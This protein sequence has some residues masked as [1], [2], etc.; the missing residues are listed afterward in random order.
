[1]EFIYEFTQTNSFLEIEFPVPKGTTNK[2]ISFEIGEGWIRVG[3][4]GKDPVICGQLVASVIPKESSFSVVD[5]SKVVVKIHKLGEAI[6]PLIIRSDYNG[7]MDANSE[8]MLSMFYEKQ[9]NIPRAYESLQKSVKKKHYAGIMKMAA[10]YTYQSVFPIPVD[11]KKA[12]ELWIES[13]KQ[14]NPDSQYMVG[15]FY[16]FG[17]SCEKNYAKAIEFYQKSHE[18]GN[19][20][21]GINAGALYY[22]GGYGIKKNLPLAIKFWQ[23]SSDR[24]KQP[25]AMKNLSIVYYLGEGIE[26]DIHKAK[27][28]LSQALSIDPNLELSPVLE[29]LKKIKEPEEETEKPKEIQKIQEIKETEKPKEIQEIK[30]IKETQKPKETKETQKS[31]EIKEIKRN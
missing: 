26:K 31:K 17:D 7:E 4:K 27:E 9:G 8:Y 23:E 2:Q 14:N 6:W 13:A 1:M 28:Y 19:Q 10:L 18:N 3:L 24:F 25:E 5:Q 22:E 21:S 20:Y 15:N 16:Q 30:E 29:T 12:L 11:H